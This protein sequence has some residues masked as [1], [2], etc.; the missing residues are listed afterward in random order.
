MLNIQFLIELLHH[1]RVLKLY[2][3]NFFELFHEI[4]HETF[5][6]HI[7][8]KKKLILIYNFNGKY[9]KHLYLTKV[10]MKN[11]IEIFRT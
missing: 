5:M 10:L 3:I 11:I 4:F 8:D 2:E 6:C 7:N 9:S 1:F